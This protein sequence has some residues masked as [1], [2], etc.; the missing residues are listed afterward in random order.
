[1]FDGWNDQGKPMIVEASG[2]GY[3]MRRPMPDRYYARYDGTY[4]WNQMDEIQ[5]RLGDG[6]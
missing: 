3:C 4:R 1:M 5:K 6:A 2:E